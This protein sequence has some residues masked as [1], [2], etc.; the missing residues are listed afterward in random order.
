MNNIINSFYSFKHTDHNSH[1]PQRKDRD[2]HFQEFEVRLPSLS[3]SDV[4][5][6]VLNSHHHFRAVRRKLTLT[7]Y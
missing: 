2:S 7:V 6:K 4:T 3:N 5:N 1:R